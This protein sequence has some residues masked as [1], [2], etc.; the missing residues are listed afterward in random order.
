MSVTFRISFRSVNRDC[1]A[2][3]VAVLSVFYLLDSIY[4]FYIWRII[5]TDAAATSTSI[6]D[7]QT[8]C[9]SFNV[10]M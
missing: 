7:A 4:I 10:G 9:G 6:A 5:K 3:L 2:S 8:Q 1:V